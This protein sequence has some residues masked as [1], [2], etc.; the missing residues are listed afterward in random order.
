MGCDKDGGRVRKL[1]LKSS[2]QRRDCSDCKKMDWG[3]SLE[4]QWL[5]L[6]TSSAGG[7]GSIPGQ[8]TRSHRLQLTVHMP[9]PK[10][11][12]ASTNIWQRLIN[13]FL[14]LKK[15]SGNVASWVRSLGWE[16]PPGEGKDYP[17]QYS[18]L[19]NSMDCVVYGVAKSRAWLSDFHSFNAAYK[20]K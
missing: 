6:Y 19:E 3:A 17:L 7:L 2:F 15:E 20:I 14:F 5:E 18:G 1:G 16:D 4:V 13:T 11:S 9:R 10:A 12:C 8:G